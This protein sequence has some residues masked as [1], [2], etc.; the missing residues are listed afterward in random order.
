MNFCGKSGCL[1][2]Q[3]KQSGTAYM[4]VEWGR[5]NDKQGGEA[6]VQKRGAEDND[7]DDDQKQKTS[8]FK[9]MIWN[10]GRYDVHQKGSPLG[11]VV[12]ALKKYQ[13]PVKKK[14][15]RVKNTKREWKIPNL[16]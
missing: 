9:L 10:R 6:S 1:A 14:Q 16:S 8:T 5:T 15:T 2:I 4:P 3:G 7:D 11:Q 12:E 13:M